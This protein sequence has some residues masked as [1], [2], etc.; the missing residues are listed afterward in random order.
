MESGQVSWVR[1]FGNFVAVVAAEDKGAQH[2]VSAGEAEWRKKAGD[3]PAFEHSAL[4]DRTVFPGILYLYDSDTGKLRNI[5]THQGDSEIL[6]VEDLTV[7]YRVS[8]RIY[9]ASITETGFGPAKLMGQDESLRDAHWA[10][11]K[12]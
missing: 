6:L 4:F 5:S 7:Y 9:S 3:G 11:V 2:P 12:R 1:A 10:F 8:D